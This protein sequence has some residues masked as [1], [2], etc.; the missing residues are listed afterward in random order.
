MKPS[1]KNQFYIV[2]LLFVVAFSCKEKDNGFNWDCGC[3]GS[4]SKVVK[5]VKASYLG[6]SSLLLPLPGENDQFFEHYVSVCSISDTLKITPDIKNPDYIVSGNLKKEC[7]MGQ[8]SM[9]VPASFEI[10]S[11]K[12]GL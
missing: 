1:S 12:R 2:C 10:T 6:K 7:S 5:N 3:N 9:Y 4:T 8:N 11:I